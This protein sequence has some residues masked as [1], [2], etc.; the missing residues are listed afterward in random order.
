MAGKKNE[1]IHQRYVV[2]FEGVANS[3]E[4]AIERSRKHMANLTFDK[5]TEKHFQSTFKELEK[6]L[7]SLKKRFGEGIT[8][9]GDEAAL[10]KKLNDIMT[11]WTNFGKELTNKGLK[12]EDIFFKN[13]DFTKIEQNLQ[14]LE[15][16][17]KALGKTIK[18]N[19]Q[20]GADVTLNKETKGRIRH[21]AAE[22]TNTL[23]EQVKKEKGAITGTKD[24]KDAEKVKTKLEKQ[25][26]QK[27]TEDEAIN[28][29][30]TETSIIE[31]LEEQ[32]REFEAAQ[33][34]IEAMNRAL[35][36]QKQLALD[37]AEAQ[38][39]A[40][41]DP[42][43]EGIKSNYNANSATEAYNIISQEIA[44][45][46]SSKQQTRKSEYEN[47]LKG[48][49]SKNVDTQQNVLNKYGKQFGTDNADELKEILRIQIKEQAEL[50]K[51]NREIDEKN[52]ALQS[53]L[54]TLKEVL[55]IEKEIT[56]MQSKSDK[57]EED[58]VAGDKTIE[59]FN[60]KTGRKSNRK[61]ISKSIDTEMSRNS[62][63]I[64]QENE[65]LKTNMALL[66][67]KK[68]KEQELSNIDAYSQAFEGEASE[69]DKIQVEIDENIAE[70]LKYVENATK[71][72]KIELDGLEREA[73]ESNKALKQG[74]DVINKYGEETKKA[75]AASKSFKQ[76]SQFFASFFSVQT[77]IS[78]A[79]QAIRGAINDIKDLD[80]QLNEISIVTGKSMQELWSNFGKLNSLA[81]Q[82]GVTTGD[83]VSVQKLYYQQGRSVAEVN[84]LT[85]ETLTF[86]KI[87]GLEFGEA[88]EYMTAAL[89]AFKIEA[90]DASRVTDTYAALSMSAAVDANELAVAMSKVASLAALSNSDLEETSAYLAKIIET[91]REAPETA[92]T[93]LKTVIARFTA[94][95]KLTE[96]QKE[97][98]DEDYNFNN[99]EKALKTV[100]VS[101]KDARGEMRGFGEIIQ[102]LGPKWKNL[103][104]NQKHYIATQAAGARQQSRFIALMDDWGRTQELMEVA[105]DSAGTGAEQLELSMDS[106][107]SK[108]NQ[109]K[110]T[111]Q[112]FYG[113]LT[114]SE[115]FKFVIDSLNNILKLLNNI[116]DT[117]G[118]F[119]PFIIAGIAAV[120]AALVKMAIKGATEFGKSF[121]KTW[122]DI[123][124]K[125]ELKRAKDDLKN[126]A[127]KGF[128]EGYEYGKHFEKGKDAAEQEEKVKEAFTGD[129]DGGM[130]LEMD[131]DLPEVDSG[132]KPGQKLLKEGTEEVGEKVLKE[133]VEEAGEKVLKEGAEEIAET[134]LSK[135]VGKITPFISKITGGIG[136]I[137][138]GLAKGLG[139]VSRVVTKFLPVIGVITAIWGT[140]KLIQ[141]GV[142][143][144][145]EQDSKKA[146]ENLQKSK[147]DLDS[148]LKKDIALSTTYNRIKELERKNIA[149]TTEETAEYQSKLK[150][151]QQE[152]PQLIKK[153]EQGMLELVEGADGM[154]ADLKDKNEADISTYH[155]QIRDNAAEAQKRGTYATQEANDVN[156]AIKSGLAVL[157]EKS[158]E[159]LKSMGG[160]D[161]IQLT[162]DNL[163]TLSQNGINY[164]SLNA[165]LGFGDSFTMGAYDE[166]IAEYL[167]VTQETGKNYVDAT[168]ELRISLSTEQQKIF[169]VL[170]A[171]NKQTGTNMLAELEEA[172]SIATIMKNQIGDVLSQ[173]DRE[174]GGISDTLEENVKISVEKMVKELDTKKITSTT[175]EKLGMKEEIEATVK[176]GRNA[177]DTHKNTVN[178]DVLKAFEQG[179]EKWQ[180]G[181]S[182]HDEIKADTLLAYIESKSTLDKN[183][184]H[185]KEAYTAVD[186]FKQ[187]KTTYDDMFLSLQQVAAISGFDLTTD[188]FALDVSAFGANIENLLTDDKIYEYYDSMIDE[189]VSLSEDSRK[190]FEAQ[191]ESIARMSTNELT[192]FKPEDIEGF[193]TFGPEMQD[194]LTYHVIEPEKAEIEQ[195]IS[196]Q[197]NILFSMAPA[198]RQN[199]K[200]FLDELNLA[201]LNYISEGIRP[202]FEK[203]GVE[204]A[205]GFGQEFVHY[206]QKYIQGNPVLTKTFQ[207]IDFFDPASMGDA[208]SQ[209]ISMYGKSSGAYKNYI[210]MINQ[211]SNLIDR[212]FSNVDQII[213]KATADI[214][215]LTKGLE[216]ITTALSGGLGV[217]QLGTLLSEYG[218]IIDVK[219][220]QATADGFLLDTE[221][222]L[223]LKKKMF[224]LTVEDYKFQADMAASQ[225]K[226]AKDMLKEKGIDY[227][228][229]YSLYNKEINGEQLSETEQATKKNYEFTIEKQ[230]LEQELQIALNAEQTVPYY[231]Q[232]VNLMNQMD[233]EYEQANAELQK[234]IEQLKTLKTLLEQLN[235]YSDLDAYM[236]NLQDSI[237]Q[238]DFELEFSTNVDNIVETTKDKMAVLSNLVNTNLAKADRARENTAAR[239]KTLSENWGEYIDFDDLGNVLLD[240]AAMA[241][242]AER[243]A[244]MPTDTKSQ[245]ETQ[246]KAKERYQEVLNQVEAYRN[247]KKMIDECVSA[248]QDY[249]KQIEEATKAMRQDV[250]ALEDKFRD[251]FIKRDEDA[252]E[253]LEKRYDAMKQMDEDYLNSVREAIEKERQL[254]DQTNE[255]ED[256]NKMQ[257]QLELMR[258]SGGSATEIQALEQEIA[259]KQQDM[260]DSRVDT[261]IDEIE[262]Q[263][264]KQASEMDKEVTYQKQ[265]L[266]AKKQNQILYNQE[267]AALMNQDKET[268]METW[269]ILDEE[270]ASATTENK[271]LLEAEMEAMVAKGK[272]SKEL[273]ADE[274]GYIPALEEAYKKVKEAI[275]IDID[276]MTEFS[277]EIVE[278]G[279]ENGE[280]VNGLK[281]IEESYLGI[282][283]V[284]QDK[285]LPNVNDL[286]TKLQQTISY[287]S[288]VNTDFKADENKFGDAGH[289]NNGGKSIYKVTGSEHIGDTVYWKTEDGKYF[290][291]NKYDKNSEGNI[292]T[293]DSGTTYDAAMIQEWKKGGEL[294]NNGAHN[295]SKNKTVDQT[296]QYSNLRF[297]DMD[298]GKS[299][300]YNFYLF[301]G[302]YLKRLDDVLA[303]TTASN[304]TKVDYGKGKVWDDTSFTAGDSIKDMPYNG[305][306]VAGTGTTPAGRAII[307][308][309]QE[310]T[311]TNGWVPY[312]LFKQFFVPAY[313]EGGMVDFTGPAW[314]DGTKSKPEAFLSASDTSLIASLRDVL[315]VNGPYGL[316]KT[317]PVQKAGD[318]YYEIHINVDELGDGYS[319]DDLMNELEDRIVQ[320]ADKNTVIKISR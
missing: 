212:D 218:S 125:S 26:G 88:T 305:W 43:V 251:L 268:I 205:N 314:V 28:Y 241:K 174:A 208:A 19:L 200:D 36:T 224:Q 49:N 102:E 196:E 296:A 126:A 74:A 44:Q 146:S 204:A 244:A 239:K 68:K 107:E 304:L 165:A 77:L 51:Q 198:I 199:F 108:L 190:M 128:K 236:G 139:V 250:V 11:V 113:S 133:G 56:N 123:W 272:S 64:E 100:G 48:L 101:T 171:L 210:N 235:E 3:L 81:Q 288:Q 203:Y 254:R 67:K 227:D 144:F 263:S 197:K 229:Y 15:K 120:A 40:L 2:E 136:K 297:K 154:I 189:Y 16:K 319:V 188:T 313:A 35:E 213:K 185:W 12:V 78:Q 85:G 214:E 97:L 289:G 220:F 25:T 151:L 82:Y 83:V 62:V 91:T 73:I 173:A 31:A 180:Q 187:G 279:S 222:A 265:V 266:D 234:Q 20:T 140:I 24:Y 33:K 106:I 282:N 283:S 298:K 58:V 230:G 158:A 232:L 109:L 137:G 221:N 238:Y 170:N 18:E 167:R 164:D 219:D 307:N 292:V 306:Y 70:E 76:I 116:M 172:N 253:S 177:I 286:N 295:V 59:D 299:E 129:S 27:F 262:Q 149:R 311:N 243:I 226:H 291:S 60:A 318:T 287:Q 124:E 169:A 41:S 278:A 312:D 186:Q 237:K 269:R 93:A 183:D 5:N 202:I 184:S 145:Q 260:A 281:T 240:E 147:K 271:E 252:L 131:L 119:G 316:L 249:T 104:E 80:K 228:K 7:Q 117:T 217:E 156:D 320:S 303:N 255:E 301:D 38:K 9:P 267:I 215:Q 4:Q 17:A 258:M 142:K 161:S 71:Q 176:E 181:E 247:E 66:E 284:I 98:L 207:E 94:I 257:R 96:D 178:E 105:T 135:G 69:V 194:F 115:A 45:N 300:D 308:L 270:F 39:T 37:I 157:S 261:Y 310:G 182:T 65:A 290:N 30:K 211:S 13:D 168:D 285:L 63:K 55:K 132:K 47:A 21:A 160:I 8:S 103:T 138:G 6:D 34:K 61:N 90:Q 192:D 280:V 302:N 87:S 121:S 166:A 277:D 191:L 86:A 231:E 274:G 309:K 273:L 159:E 52:R 50:V 54:D 42:E 195:F 246:E 118:V 155:S 1:I 162:S 32:N 72:A 293:A 248:A 75:A 79:T 209:I 112:S 317:Q 201:S 89:N 141:K 150:E 276:T 99:I 22:G 193:N 275:D 53:Q 153:N 245:Q 84:E 130:Q 127:E 225:K 264:Q 10:H 294:K 95:N 23:K 46:K 110:G 122:R 259:Q 143:W 14:K 175:F 223:E 134:A 206:Y 233:L 216:N 57:L 92:G 242:W 114:S 315:R 148:T 111:W 256:L 179:I 152:Y 163:A 29:L